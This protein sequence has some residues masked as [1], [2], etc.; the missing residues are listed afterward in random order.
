MTRLR[1]WLCVTLVE[2]QS[3][4]RVRALSVIR[5]GSRFVGVI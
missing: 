2:A 5:S 4:S 1:T 3:R